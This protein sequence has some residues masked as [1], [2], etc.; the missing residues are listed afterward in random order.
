[1]VGWGQTLV[2]GL[3]V[4]C[5]TCVASPMTL[6]AQE[7]PAEMPQLPG[8]PV[9]INSPAGDSSGPTPEPGA[10]APKAKA[11]PVP[12]SGGPHPMQLLDSGVP[13]GQHPAAAAPA[14]QE[15]IPPSFLSPT[16]VGQHPA[17]APAVQESLLKLGESVQTI[18]KN[19]TVVT[20]TEHFKLILGGVIS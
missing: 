13:P 7:A 20:G 17:A 4:L 8:P 19:L 5:A 9:P 3:L 2:S 1:M 18:A 15:S 12:A 14:V 11:A 10:V 6:R 16:L